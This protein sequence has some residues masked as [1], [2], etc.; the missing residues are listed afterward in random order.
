MAT[1][2]PE[3]QDT[4]PGIPQIKVEEVTG[5][6]YRVNFQYQGPNYALRQGSLV[7]PATT[8]VQARMVAN[9]SLKNTYGDKWFNIT[10]I[11]IVQHEEVP[12]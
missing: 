4:L 7:I 6:I 5:A 8:I 9:D 12:F 3:V 2:K 1:R 11:K 10:S